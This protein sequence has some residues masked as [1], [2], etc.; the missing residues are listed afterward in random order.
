M[1]SGLRLAR[2][3]A[4]L[5]QASGRRPQ[6]AVQLPLQDKGIDPRKYPIIKS[7]GTV[8]K[9]DLVEAVSNLAFENAN[10]V[11]QIH[12]ATVDCTKALSGPER[13]SAVAAFFST[14]RLASVWPSQLAHID[15]SQI[16]SGHPLGGPSALVPKSFTCPTKAWRRTTSPASVISTTGP[17]LGSSAEP[18]SRI[19]EPVPR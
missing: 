11:K 5:Q 2:R 13:I 7:N 10:A 18:P 16:M 12:D 19:P 17:K 6:L 4:L 9:T 14:E 1:C 8:D 3:A 15:I